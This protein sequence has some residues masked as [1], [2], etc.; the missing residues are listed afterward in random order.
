MQYYR[1]AWL[2]Y[3]CFRRSQDA[4]KGVSGIVFSLNQNFLSLQ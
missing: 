4:E 1:V 3:A 2:F